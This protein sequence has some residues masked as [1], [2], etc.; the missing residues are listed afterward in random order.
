MEAQERKFWFKLSQMISNSDLAKELIFLKFKKGYSPFQGVESVKV[1][2]EILLASYRFISCDPSWCRSTWDWR[3]LWQLIDY[4]KSIEL[5]WLS[6]QC[7]R[8]LCDISDE[9]Y[10]DWM[11][12]NFTPDKER[13]LRLKYHYIYNDNRNS[14]AITNGQLQSAN[15]V[16]I[17]GI[18]MVKFDDSSSNVTGKHSQLIVVP[19]VEVN[20]RKLA[21]ALSE[22]HPILIEGPLG[23]GKTSLIE[24]IS[25]LTG[26][27]KPPELTKIQIG[28]Q[29]DGKLLV[30]TYCCT[31]I[32]GEFVW[33]PGPLTEA[34][35]KGHWLVFEDIDSASADVLTI[36][37]SIVKSR[38]L[39]AI[40]GCYVSGATI[41]PRFRLFFTRRIT[42]GHTEVFSGSDKDIIIKMCEK[43]SLDN[44][45]PD[46][47]ETIISKR[48]PM[49]IP[50]LSVIR[51][52]YDI[53]TG[54]DS[55]DETQPSF[56]N[57]KASL[58]DFLKWCQRISTY[59]D[60]LILTDDK[61]KACLLD[62]NDCFLAN[63][64]D[65]NVRMIKSQ[66][67]GV[68]LHIATAISRQILINHRPDIS[69]KRDIISIGRT[70]LKGITCDKLPTIGSKQTPFSKTN[71]SLCLLE[72]IAC[73]V[74]HNE[75]VLLVGE[76]GTGKTSTVQ[77]LCNLLNR[78]LTVI[79]MNQQSDTCD[80][81]GGYKP[82][83]LSFL[84]E[85]IRDEFEQIFSLTFCQ[86]DNAKFLRSVSPLFR[87]Q[88][89]DKFLD[90]ILHVQTSA[91]KGNSRT[92]KS[93][94]PE[95][96][97]NILKRWNDL[98]VRI[99][100]LKTSSKD[101]PLVFTYVE[102]TLVKAM[103]RGDW[104]LMD[105][106]NLAES[107]T[108][109]CLSSILEADDGNVLLL[110][111][112]DGEPIKKHANFRL[113]AC[114]NPSTDIGKRDLPLGIRNRFTEFYVE[115]LESESD[116]R[117][118][119]ST[120]LQ[121]AFKTSFVEQIVQF[122]LSIRKEAKKTLKDAVG[123]SPTF[124]LR[125]LCRALQV[126]VSINFD[127]SSSPRALYEAFCLSF[128]T[129]LNSE[130]YQQVELMI[131]KNILKVKSVSSIAS[132]N[133]IKPKSGDYL[134]IDGYWIPKGANEPV[135]DESYILTAS[136]DR[137]L[138]DVARIISLGRSYPILIQGETS[139][140][141]TSMI[142][143]L[144]KRS[145]NVCLRVNNH[146]HTD[147]Q[148]Y[149]G[150][151]TADDKGKLVFKEGVLVEA[152]R[153][154]Y[155]IILDELNLAS[156]EVLESLNRVLDENR[157][158]F[159]P[160]TQ[161]TVK[162]HPKFLLFATQNPPGHYGGRKMLSRAFRNRFIELHFDEIPA[163]ELEIILQKRCLLPPTYAKKMVVTLT[164][165]RSRLHQ[166]VSLSFAGKHGGVTLRDLFRWGE[167]YRIFAKEY[168]S[169]QRFYNWDQHLANE[170]YMLLA[171][172]SRNEIEEQVI[173]EVL[174]K[175]FKLKISPE[176]IFEAL[177][178]E[179]LARHSIPDEFRHLFWTTPL[180]RQAVLVFQALKY[181]EP[182][183]LVG[184]TGCGKTTICQLFAAMKNKPLFSVNC[185]MH[186]ES[187]DFLG[188]LRPV[189]S[190]DESDEADKQQRLFEWVDGPLVKAMQLGSVFLIDEISLADDSVLERLNSVIEPERLLLLTEKFIGK[191]DSDHSDLVIKA[192]PDFHL[193]STMN[194]GGDYG[195]K[196]LSPALRNRFT[197]IWCYSS[198]KLSDLRQI[199]SHNL[200]DLPVNLKENIVTSLISFLEWFLSKTR[201]SG[202][203]FISIRDVLSLVEFIST[204]LKPSLD[205]E[206]TFN[207]VDAIHHAVHLV[208]LDSMGSSGSM[209]RD[210][211]SSKKECEI[212]L[213]SILSK[214]FGTTNSPLQ[215]IELSQRSDILGISPF[216]IPKGNFKLSSSS[217]T[218]I[219]DSQ[220]V[221]SNA[222]RLLRAMQLP[223]P[224]LIEGVPGVG[225]TSLVQ[226]LAKIANYQVIRI[227]LSEQTD[228]SDLF[229][230]D[231]PVEGCEGQFAWRDGPL[232][233]ALKNDSC[234]V[235]LDE[236]N[237]A[238]QSVLE[239][240]NA[241][242]DHRG[243]IFIPELSKTF[244]VSKQATRIFACQNPHAQG[245]DRKG[246]PKSFLNRFTLI[247]VES[248][249]ADDLKFIISNVH[250]TLPSDIIDK[251][252]QFNE[253]LSN[254]INSSN[255]FGRKGSPWEFN[256][257]DI[258]R[259]CQLVLSSNECENIS[260]D[261][262]ANSMKIIYSHR[263]RTRE[264]I[265]VVE[266][267]FESTFDCKIKRMTTCLKLYPDLL[268]VGQSFLPRPMNGFKGDQWLLLHHQ[269]PIIEALMK[270]VE[271]NWMALIVG[272]SQ[273]GKSSLVHLLS[274]LVGANLKT[275]IVNSEMDTIELL[276]GFNQKDIIHDIE[277][278]E[279]SIEPLIW[280]FVRYK[281]I[282]CEYG[283]VRE[284]LKRWSNYKKESSFQTP[285]QCLDR[286]NKLSSI[287]DQV[288]LNL[289]Q[290]QRDSLLQR[291]STLISY[292]KNKTS[293]TSRGSFQWIDSVLVEALREGDWLLIDDTNLCPASVLDRLNGLLEPDGELVLNEQGCVDGNVPVVRPHPNFRLFLTIDP[294]NG[295]L[296]RAMRNRGVEI[297]ILPTYNED[298]IR[299]Q[300]IKI[301]LT[302]S[303]FQE[304]L[305]AHHSKLLESSQQ[306]NDEQLNGS[307]LVRLASRIALE[308]KCSTSIE[309]ICLHYP[310][311]LPYQST[312]DIKSKKSE[313]D[314]ESRDFKILL[315]DSLVS[316]VN[317]EISTV[318][319][320]PT[321]LFNSDYEIDE[322]IQIISSLRCFISRS[323]QKDF[324][325]RRYLIDTKFGVSLD[326]SPSDEDLPSAIT[327]LPYS[328]TSSEYLPIDLRFNPI[329]WERLSSQFDGIESAD[330]QRN[331]NRRSLRYFNWQLNLIRKYCDNKASTS[332]LKYP[333]DRKLSI[334]TAKNQELLK[335]ISHLYSNLQNQCEQ[336]L[337][338]ISPSCE[339]LYELRTIFIWIHQF[340]CLL[341]SDC[342]PIDNKNTVFDKL[343]ILWV[344][345]QDKLRTHQ[346][347]GFDFN[348]Q[349]YIKFNSLQGLDQKTSIEKFS[350][351]KNLSPSLTLYK[352]E[353]SASL[354]IKSM[355]LSRLL[356][357]SDNQ[358]TLNRNTQICLDEI[359]QI[360]DN[361]L[362]ENCDYLMLSDQLT[363]LE[364]KIRESVFSSDNNS[365]GQHDDMDERGDQELASSLEKP[366]NR[367][368]QLVV[369]INYFSFF[370]KQ[371][372]HLKSLEPIDSVI[373]C[374]QG[375][376]ISPIHS[377]LI[378]CLPFDLKLQKETLF[379]HMIDFH[380][381]LSCENLYSLLVP[382]ENEDSTNGK[383][384]ETSEWLKSGYSFSSSPVMTLLSSKLLNSESV[385]GTI[386]CKINCID[387][388]Q[389]YVS[390]N[391]ET[392]V[393]PQAHDFSSYHLD[394]VV[395]LINNVKPTIDDFL[396]QLS[397]EYKL[398]FSQLC[399][400]VSGDISQI[401]NHTKGTAMI[402][403]GCILAHL[404]SPTMLI[405]PLQKWSIKLSHYLEELKFLDE[406]LASQNR[407]SIIETGEPIIPESDHPHVLQ[408]LNRKAIVLKK[409]EK[410]K[411]RQGHR[412]VPSQYQKLRDDVI[413]F[414]STI[415]PLE[416]VFELI[417]SFDKTDLVGLQKSISHFINHIHNTYPLYANV[418]NEMLLG[419]L[420]TLNGLNLSSHE[421]LT[422]KTIK[423]YEKGEKRENLT[424]ILKSMF[425]FATLDPITRAID[426]IDV[427]KLKGFQNLTQRTKLGSVSCSNLLY[428]SA[429]AELK[430]AAH[431]SLIPN[432]DILVTLFQ[433]VN[434]F[435][436]Y[437]LTKEEERKEKLAEEESLFQY[438]AK[439]HPEELPEEVI[440]EKEIKRRFPTYENDFREFMKDPIG[441]DQTS[442][443]DS[444]TKKSA[445]IIETIQESDIVEICQLHADVSSVLSRK[446]VQSTNSTD[447]FKPL[448]YRYQVLTEI[449]DVIG[450][451]LGRNLDQSS[452][453]C[454]WMMTR[455]FEK[456]LS[457]SLNYNSTSSYNFYNDP[458]PEEL[459]ECYTIL[460]PLKN[461]IINE[462]LPQF[463]GNPMLHQ[464]LKIIERLY[465]LD[466]NS[467][468][469]K[470][471]TG[472]EVLLRAA[473][474][475][476]Q[477]AHRKIKL[478]EQLT[479]VTSLVIKW[480]K[481]ELKCWS[482]L[483][484]SVH[485]EIEHK[486]IAK[487]WF[488]FYSMIHSMLSMDESLMDDSNEE[489][490]KQL[491]S[492]LKQFLEESTI[493]QFKPRLN[494]LRNFI[495]HQLCVDSTR[496]QLPL[497]TILVN[498]HKYFSQFESSVSDEI[499]KI[500]QPIEKELKE[501]V[502][503]MRWNDGNFWSLKSKVEKS[504][505]TLHRLTKKYEKSLNVP[506][507]PFLKISKSESDLKA[508]LL[509]NQLASD[510][511]V[512][513]LEPIPCS[514]LQT[515][516]RSHQ[517]II[518]VGK[519]SKKIK[520]STK[521]LRKSI[522][523]LDQRTG[524]IV[525]GIK[526]MANLKVAPTIKEKEKYE[527]E[528][529]G[530]NNM[531]RQSF[532]TLL[533]NLGEWGISFKK[534]IEMYNSFD[535]NETLATCFPFE[536]DWGLA[537][538]KEESDSADKYFYSALMRYIDFKAS[539][540][541]PS[542]DLKQIRNVFERLRGI[543]GFM[544]NE[545]VTS[546]R[547]I[548]NQLFV[549]KK[550]DKIS[551]TISKCSD[552]QTKLSSS[553]TCDHWLSTLSSYRLSL[554]CLLHQVKELPIKS[555]TN[556]S[557][558]TS[559]CNDSL[560]D[561]LQIS[562]IFTPTPSTIYKSPIATSKTESQLETA[563]DLMATS[564]SKLKVHLESIK[565]S[566][567]TVVAHLS[568]LCD[569]ISNDLII[570]RARYLETDCSVQSGEITQLVY[571][572]CESFL[573]SILSHV[574]ILFKNLEETQPS[575]EN[576][577][578]MDKIYSQVSGNF[579]DKLNLIGVQQKAQ[580]ILD[581]IS[582]SI[583][584]Q[585]E[586]QLTIYQDIIVHMHSYLDKYVNLVNYFTRINLSSFR[587]RC[588]LLFI[589]LGLFTDV[590]KQGFCLPPP[591]QDENEKTDTK[592]KFKDLTDAG[593]GEGEGEEDVSNKIESEDQLDEALPSGAQKEEDKSNDKD[594][595][596]EKNG[597]EMSED[598]EAPEFGPDEKDENN[599]DKEESEEEEEEDDLDKK[600]G[601][602][603]E[604]EGLDDKMWGDD[605]E[606]EDE[607]DDEDDLDDDGDE[608]GEEIG[609]DRL[610]AKDDNQGV[611]EK[612]KGKDKNK[613]DKD[614]S[615][616][617]E[618]NEQEIDDEYEG[619]RQ[620]P[621]KQKG[622]GEDEE[623]GGE[624]AEEF[625]EDME[626][627]GNEVGEGGDEAEE[628]DKDQEE[629]T[630]EIDSDAL[631]DENEDQPGE[632]DKDETKDEVKIPEEVAADEEEKSADEEEK[633]EG[634]GE[635]QGEEDEKMMSK[636]MK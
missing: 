65:K 600:M 632:P 520:V 205:K 15:T 447:I 292:I 1:M 605:E 421:Q 240:L 380:R 485:R 270:C 224:I 602:I 130:S 321:S 544:L 579:L 196:E 276:G 586:Q 591:W 225:K 397:P 352:D 97:Q 608:G 290:V 227:N 20:L 508:I 448:I 316:T 96:Q 62:A 479:P 58:R 188:S 598:F 314:F 51:E 49:L 25:E 594:I 185:H 401:D 140:G 346:T 289:P 530:I 363:K 481:M 260:T 3:S 476:E 259:W 198:T 616:T 233:Q 597:I 41:D 7:I 236:L 145:G 517:L 365:V 345:V 538:N 511:I 492:L 53:V 43:I 73:A 230:A 31:D 40:P 175:N 125:T 17:Y 16:D 121:S 627:D 208:F 539:L 361:L 374:L 531:K 412:P 505:R 83:E 69:I 533:K 318:S 291:L 131:L 497:F 494:L 9:Y 415:L 8:I 384:L 100:N 30:G 622:E 92:L 468:L 90:V 506:V 524:D 108:L 134:S 103:R 572:K 343:L 269:T 480:R 514:D 573:V 210:A 5:K 313:F 484:E 413:Q 436:N 244:S 498:L 482:T 169:S 19:S 39:S 621:Y 469:A 278:I 162:A 567:G 262:I 440:D 171:G 416:K 442:I 282:K 500:R 551:E 507:M 466:I 556:E 173:R 570:F 35:L 368:A 604:S 237:L 305:F 203:G 13:E 522:K 74:N 359:V 473:E 422:S 132:M 549:L 405:D 147:L 396:S 249:T 477:M 54:N 186:S 409:I 146:E 257:R 177:F 275:I 159:I 404:W 521:N 308:L 272:P 593:L 603:D 167:R 148:E 400:Q 44:P 527:K 216:F 128:L 489:N 266:K 274:Q 501:F 277:R 349:L 624:E 52:I 342:G 487:N 211:I 115:E 267:L 525:E 76:T 516:S 67:V 338:N 155:W 219:F 424:N 420:I 178:D 582:S 528:V 179:N 126:A 580:D 165:L 425:Q 154:G 229:G 426:A 399:Q 223:K 301:G 99:N 617:E 471:V 355:E 32:I 536:P 628:E 323:S 164:E 232:L 217:S 42:D 286:L 610:V 474:D 251:M 138:R 79:N 464:L 439:T 261:L 532:S 78:H 215:S 588:K 358:L 263:F 64:S 390:N 192:H 28:N 339:E 360:Y 449:V 191:G 235:L 81:L 231:L 170:G 370:W 581:T 37:L 526:E 483:L 214:I 181:N 75:P 571:Q 307:Y 45:S 518:K 554:Q 105:E 625:P 635:E 137:N 71:S 295:E 297:Y 29:V 6:M 613:D 273:S 458:K 89:W 336:K 393:D 48:W 486:Q 446:K 583:N 27:S 300:M 285:E 389:T 592:D 429:L 47:L 271:M 129:Q 247:H 584:L 383:V 298:D 158:L 87:H 60:T 189:R 455:L 595:K 333:N 620:D 77:H 437:W 510:D 246:L 418:S 204:I 558:L 161:E 379:Y 569:K 14:P 452:A 194:P 465:T 279:N 576:Q 372:C 601:D 124:T 2:R 284:I 568:E 612:S 394:L 634:E 109:Q 241:C 408:A 636:M 265:V 200:V 356:N 288:T 101:I 433:V 144:A 139:V 445:K 118:L 182:V 335:L 377:V 330:Y 80:L 123:G 461:R 242:L 311:L 542:D 475:W 226:S 93:Q 386:G 234:W 10:F 310:E 590:C 615:D 428:K 156:T 218:F 195:K 254:E 264:D 72:R 618:I 611:K 209:I 626:L 619:E 183:L 102:G 467:P 21:I 180:K 303:T 206:N 190:H 328:S 378:K 153:K 326:V 38:S 174:S 34:L 515:L 302:N 496:S 243:E 376:C 149:V 160:E 306:L 557:E 253:K 114:M 369:P 172:R 296:S 341:S 451:T 553:T 371:T 293:L 252:V 367:M 459:R 294:K 410:L 407:I 212:K 141:K 325:Y 354:F 350:F 133:L 184:E 63:I 84:M 322:L 599:E 104:I 512:H 135:T 152:M 519:Y 547:R 228:V 577:V 136:V 564:S 193:I 631:P 23:C 438:K 490:E 387:K 392:L 327:P 163:K 351:K 373:Q 523:R 456:T 559:I 398:T 176:E 347:I 111:K 107:E 18:K 403:F 46:E 340:F 566:P 317:K 364:S 463:P 287:A 11:A 250:K 450:P 220:T 255:S 606:S 127:A 430:N 110:D 348:Q 281:S 509:P 453:E 491:L 238:S 113:F 375:V 70:H 503:I 245:G 66:E 22:N 543:V 434:T 609:D 315:G 258:F 116:L 337:L 187:A 432:Y 546:K 502:K 406:E 24:H 256:L 419:L 462:L 68:K 57:R 417:K 56:N 213:N 98:G 332:L 589:L 499:A 353:Q 221:A 414:L 578:S 88:K 607:D 585:D 391:F 283:S 120:Y 166:S 91:L 61:R 541:C 334:I 441:M 320:I 119:V 309:Q 633:K 427:V 142:N 106:I 504:H 143:Y 454:S 117:V 537:I 33:K 460:E 197:E 548:F 555:D 402:L 94:S 630:E 59:I 540:T 344:V 304:A 85:P 495:D 248:L 388:L 55:L 431:L 86:Q 36:M 565:T 381:T 299:S 596:D 122:Y 552:R 535:L 623:E 629:K 312:L 472:L 168:A 26:R 478:V 423:A 493:G 222:Q 574:Q 470:I 550:L 560:N 319:S 382:K 562:S 4:E 534:G 95:E 329:V 150:S 202:L 82:V 411:A 201:E 151:Y 157:E 545:L 385:L 443:D 488:H 457:F 357:N 395:E 614:E 362:N 444:D 199:I 575:D 50:I 324:T 529:K 207:P 12:K 561:L 587:A 239:G 435:L 331:L 563:W 513:S 280:S 112:A 268:Q 366:L